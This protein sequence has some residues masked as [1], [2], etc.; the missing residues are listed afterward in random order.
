[1]GIFGRKAT[2]SGPDWS[3]APVPGDPQWKRHEL[4][5]PDTHQAIESAILQAGVDDSDVDR[6]ECLVRLWHMISG[7]AQIT[8]KVAG[9]GGEAAASGLAKLSERSDF[10]EDMLWNYFSHQGAL[11]VAVQHRV[12]EMFQS[13]DAVTVLAEM[14]RDGDCRHNLGGS[15]RV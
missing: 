10:S 3:T 1:M 4:P 5:R 13:G 9:Y 12:V 11:G 7:V 2:P 8:F 14:I 15:D 6:V